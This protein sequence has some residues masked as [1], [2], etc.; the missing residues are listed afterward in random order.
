MLNKKDIDYFTNELT[1]QKNFWDRLGGKPNFKDKTV[2]DFGCGH[3]AT[4]L[5]IAKDNP[6]KIVGID[7]DSSNIAFAKEN[8]DK[9]FSQYKDK[10]EFKL[11]NL[12]SWD[13][14]DKFD[15][16]VSKET[17][18]HTL[19]LETVLNSMHKLLVSKGKIFSGFG[20][21]YNFFNGDHGR[22][23]S[24]L[25][26]FHLVLPNS[27][28]IKRINKRQKKQITSI[29]ELGLNMYSLKDYLSIFK[30][31]NFE[32]K[33]LKKNCTNNPLAIIFKIMS[34]IELLE[35]FCTFNIFIVLCKK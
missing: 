11:V 18:E 12:N 3:G 21:L 32:I 27:F 6:K 13:T 20:P 31:S 22:T 10:I 15:Y 2:L 33:M 8:I 9:N 28:L 7:L 4:C 1:R 35:E 16:I 26:W 34:K 14:D 29:K 5:D 25:P 24:I 30:N 23:R 17:F 19:N